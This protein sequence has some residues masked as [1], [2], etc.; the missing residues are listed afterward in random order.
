MT[1]HYD[2]GRVLRDFDLVS[3]LARL[4]PPGTTDSA[5]R[6]GRQYDLNDHPAFERWLATFD[7]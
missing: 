2:I 5:R 1:F 6:L 4:V 3:S 7:L